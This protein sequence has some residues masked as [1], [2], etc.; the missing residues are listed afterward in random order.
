MDE[1]EVS[2][3]P[4]DMP[5]EKAIDVLKESGRS[6]LVAERSDG[7]ALLT[8]GDMLQALRASR[9]PDRP[10][11]ELQPSATASQVTLPRNSEGILDSPIRRRGLEAAFASGGARYSLIRSGTRARVITA[12]DALAFTLSRSLIICR[13]KLDPRHHVFEPEDLTVP[14]KCNFD[15]QAVNCA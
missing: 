11:G 3:V 6:A 4:G 10:V 5:L 13:C 7:L 2:L 12:S 1:I 8:S 14:G 15:G 9:N